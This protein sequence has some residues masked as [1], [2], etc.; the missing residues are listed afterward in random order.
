MI[1]KPGFHA[2]DV[3]VIEQNTVFEGFFRMEKLSL[4]HKKFDGSWTGAISREIFKRGDAAAAILYDAKNDLIGLIEQF[5]VGA[6]NSALGPWCMEVVAG[7][8]EE[9]ET[10]EEMVRRELVEE[11]GIESAV[12]EPITDYY[13]SPGGCDE[14]IHVF[15]ALCDLTAAAGDF[16]LDEEHEDI[17]LHVLPSQEVFPYM[18]SGRTNNA[19]TVIG[20]LWL[21]QHRE[22]LMAQ[23]SDEN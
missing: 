21:Q 11:A 7:M 9:G 13:S 1:D 20:L 23:H 5:R 8:I 17:R 16:G 6:L 14:K 15:C 3:E 18:L 10:A 2:T 4:R 19:A 22:R 12:L